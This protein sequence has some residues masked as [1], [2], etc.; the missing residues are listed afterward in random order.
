MIAGD[1]PLTPSISGDVSRVFTPIELKIAGK[2]SSDGKDKNDAGGQ[3]KIDNGNFPGVSI[4]T[5]DKKDIKDGHE[6]DL[7]NSG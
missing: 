6:D 2:E 4:K 7:G 3:E 1:R 5:L